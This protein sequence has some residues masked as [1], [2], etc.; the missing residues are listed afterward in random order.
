MPLGAEKAG[1]LAT[2]GAA[3]GERGVMIGG[4]AATNVIQ[5]IT[6]NTTGDASDF[7]DMSN[8][9][10]RGGAMSN[11]STDRGLQYS[12]TWTTVADNTIEYITISTA[13]NGT[14]F[15]DSYVSFQSNG[16]SNNTNDRAV[17]MGG[18]T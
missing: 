13:G 16:L 5:Y 2:S 3:A 8:A 12:G 7:G 17:T 14:D 9:V 1:L 18:W 6:I 4:Y 11:G 10:Y 15:G